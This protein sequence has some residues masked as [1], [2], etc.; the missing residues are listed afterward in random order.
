[1]DQWLPRCR[2]NIGIG[3]VIDGST[4][5]R[6]TAIV[7]NQC[8]RLRQSVKLSGQNRAWP[9]FKNSG[10]NYNIAIT[11]LINKQHTGYSSALPTVAL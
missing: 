9:A 6:C 1:M 11:I 5:R 3:N 10:I 7:T 8:A 2:S 4:A